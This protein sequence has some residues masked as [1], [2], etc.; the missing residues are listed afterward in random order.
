MN[1]PVFYTDTVNIVF[2]TARDLGYS[3]QEAKLLSQA[4]ADKWSNEKAGVRYT[5]PLLMKVKIRRRKAQI[6]IDRRTMSDADI[7]L[8]HNISR[9]TLARLP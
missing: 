3:K 8:K 9:R 5:V 6:K 2:Q 4:V 7:M 1:N